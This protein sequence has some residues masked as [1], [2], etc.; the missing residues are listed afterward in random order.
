MATSR[1]QLEKQ[2]QNLEDGGALGIKAPL[3]S[4]DPNVQ[5]ALDVDLSK[6][7]EK[8]G[9]PSQQQEI[10]D[11]M[12]QAQRAARAN[13]SSSRPSRSKEI[14]EYL[15]PPSYEEGIQKYR[16]RLE[17]LYEPSPRPGF[18]DLAS[19]LGRAMLSGDPTA[20]VF[21]SAG[22]GFSNFNGLLKQSDAENLKNRRAVAV[23]Y[24]HL[25]L[26]TIY[27]V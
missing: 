14:M 27:S 13:S 6:N 7:R 22:V 16:S 23:S 1:V 24:T 4:I 20:G 15:K 17:G 2:I 21:R 9:M 10:V 26:P 18:Y 3:P 25:T 19:E 8:F 11:L 12:E 5:A